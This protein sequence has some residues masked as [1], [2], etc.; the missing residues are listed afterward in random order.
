MTIPPQRTST[1]VRDLK[2]GDIV[3][4]QSVG[5]IVVEVVVTLGTGDL[6]LYFMTKHT[7]RPGSLTYTADAKVTVLK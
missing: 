2:F 7:A 5:H 3:D 1:P 4:H 6:R